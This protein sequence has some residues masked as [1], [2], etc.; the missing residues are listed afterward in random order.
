MLLGWQ[1]PTM[2]GLATRVLDSQESHPSV[3]LEMH[4]VGCDPCTCTCRVK[5]WCV[6]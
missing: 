1:A 5:V 4:V 6:R 2:V 3:L